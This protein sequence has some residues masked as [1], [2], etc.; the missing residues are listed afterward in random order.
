[1]ITKE[2]K[3]ELISSLK[4]KLQDENIE[5]SRLQE[6]SRRIRELEDELKFF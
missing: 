5:E 3:E 4:L 2:N 1:M 6:I